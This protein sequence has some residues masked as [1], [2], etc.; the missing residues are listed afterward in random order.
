MSTKSD[1]APASRE[2]AEALA[3][4]R[5]REA[6]L[7]EALEEIRKIVVTSTWSPYDLSVIENLAKEAIAAFGGAVYVLDAS[8]QARERYEALIAKAIY[9]TKPLTWNDS[10][11]EYRARLARAALA[12]ILPK[13]RNK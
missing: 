4:S 6:K 2:L 1:P 7:A 8:P 3:S 12:T 11:E 9:E 13:R 5:S 10:G